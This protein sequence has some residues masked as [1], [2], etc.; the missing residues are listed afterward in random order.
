MT[1]MFGE[2]TTPLGIRVG[3]RVFTE[4]IAVVVVVIGIRVPTQT[5]ASRQ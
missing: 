1:E 4:V 3:E 5:H 2:V